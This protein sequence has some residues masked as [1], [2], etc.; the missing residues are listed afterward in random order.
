MQ[1]RADTPTTS[2]AATK[3][4]P[5]LTR[6]LL[7][8]KLSGQAGMQHLIS[9]HFTWPALGQALLAAGRGGMLYFVFNRSVVAV[10]V[11]HDLGAGEFVAQVRRARAAGGGWVC[12]GRDVRMTPVFG[13]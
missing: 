13:A 1:L 8:I 10:L 3:Y 6:R 12:A 2:T 5:H 9:M 7:G 11:A 4:P